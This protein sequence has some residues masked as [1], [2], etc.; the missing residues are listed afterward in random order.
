MTVNRLINPATPASDFLKPKTGDKF[1]AVEVTLANV[2][3]AVYDEA[4]MFG[5]RL[6]DGQNQQ[7][8]PSLYQ[9]R[10]G[11]SFGGTA[12]I[13]GGD[14]RKGVL[15]FEIPQAAMPT[16]FQ[17]GLNAGIAA[18]KGEWTLS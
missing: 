18:Q 5:A 1:V 10:E 13:N 4:P 16:K 12:T 8:S 15:V 17:F 14:S 6:I 11:Q 7:Y 9:V 2:G 3:Q